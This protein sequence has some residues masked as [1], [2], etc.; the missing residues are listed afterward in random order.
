MSLLPKDLD[1]LEAVAQELSKLPPEELNEDV[2]VTRLEAALRERVKGLNLR[3]AVSRL[4]EDYAILKR[5]LKE[6]KLADGPAFW[7]AAYLMRPGAIARGLLAPPPPPEPTVSFE[8]PAG[9]KANSGPR[10]LALTKGKLFCYFMVLDNSGFESFQWDANRREELQRSSK[11]PWADLG[12]WSR[13]PVI[14]GESKGE[15]HLYIQTGKTNWKAIQYLL[16]VPGGFIHAQLGHQAGKDF[17]ETEMEQ[18]LHTLKVIPPAS[19][20]ST[21]TC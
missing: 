11:N 18:R 10:A 2:D 4:T 3:D 1:Y 12:V 9:W 7:I 17:D 20:G 6:T 8:I 15:K 16:E 19:A 5:W 13:Q 21:S 14:F